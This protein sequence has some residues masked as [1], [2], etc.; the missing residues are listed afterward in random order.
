MACR[1]KRKGWLVWPAF[2]FPPSITARQ[3]VGLKDQAIKLSSL[4]SLASEKY[5]RELS[6][7][8]GGPSAPVVAMW[9]R[10]SEFDCLEGLDR[11]RK[12]FDSVRGERQNTPIN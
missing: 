3:K 1:K 8:V 9:R 10:T 5:E 11:K 4:I 2:S 7:R 12:K 6:G